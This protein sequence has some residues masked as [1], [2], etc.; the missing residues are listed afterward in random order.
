MDYTKLIAI[1]D[2]L[3][4]TALLTERFTCEITACKGMCCV[5]GESGAPLEPEE[6]GIL[7]KEYPSFA[8]FMTL[9]GR[10]A[11]QQN[12]VAVL[13]RDGEWVTPLVRGAEC[14]YARLNR[15]GNCIC[16]IECA[17]WEGKTTFRKPI[18][19]WLYP[20]RI[21]KLSK[22]YALN[23]HQWHVC[24]SACAIG[25]KEDIRLYCFLK[26]AIIARFGKEFYDELD[27]AAAV[28]KGAV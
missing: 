26:E 6:T 10:K 19:C 16:A 2:I 22:G 13:D 24:R 15:S 14:A 5:E 12:G 23:Y 3:V 1:G 21:Q 18:S 20:V 17:F 8:H 25:Q 11:V 7:E 27:A 28:I 9:Q 4:S